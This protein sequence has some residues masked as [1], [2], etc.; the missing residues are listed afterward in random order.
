MSNKLI[1]V[2]E[3]FLSIQGEGPS[4]GVPAIFLR[5]AFCNLSCGVAEDDLPEMDAPQEE[6]EERQKD[7][8]TWVCDTLSVWREPGQRYTPSELVS[9]WED[10]G[11]IDALRNG[12]HIVLTGGEPTLPMHQRTMP[13]FFE[14][15]EDEVGDPYIEVETNGTVKPQH[16]FSSYIDQ[17]NI[18]LKLSNSGMPEE[19][20]IKNEPLEYYAT[21]GDSPFQKIKFKFVVSREEDVDEIHDIIDEYDIPDQYI[22]LMPAGAT[23]EQ[24]RE[25]YPIVADLCIENGWMFSPRIQVTTWNETT[26]V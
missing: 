18:S 13:E 25:T 3:M 26:G 15:L 1:P 2:S 8:A 12:A 21:G 23:Q 20:R 11:F 19:Q 10:R 17:Y 9:E 5:L 22:S 7:D 14:L 4:A 6:Y 24:L 16:L